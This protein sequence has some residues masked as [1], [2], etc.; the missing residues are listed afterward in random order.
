MT[1]RVRTAL[2][3][4]GASGIGLAIASAL[5]AQGMT[6]VLLDRNADALASAVAAID[7]VGAQ[8]T[9]IAADL[10]VPAQYEAAVTAAIERSSGIDVL[11]NNAAFAQLHPFEQ[12]PAEIWRR[13]L[14]INLTAPCRLS[15]LC[16]PA[17]RAQGYGRIVDIASGSGL[18][19]SQDRAAYGTS[20]AA[21]I[22]LTRQ[23]AIEVGPHGITCNAVAPGAVET[24]MSQATHTPAMRT[25]ALQSIP[26]RRYGTVQEVADAV[27]F[28]ASEPA[29]YVNGHTLCVDGGFSIAG[30]LDV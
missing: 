5:A 26:A 11:I 22:H 9:A 21:L 20:K 17:M 23:I 14:E 16:L 18:R 8:V 1:A 4:G 3:T 13:T 25:R 24:P 7:Q 28:L 30:L 12:I 10:E 19:A 29:S 6:V 15:Q 2:V 27:V